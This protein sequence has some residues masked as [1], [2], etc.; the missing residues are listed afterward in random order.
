MNILL[1]TKQGVDHLLRQFF[2]AL[3][4]NIIILGDPQHILS[5]VLEFGHFFPVKR[6]TIRLIGSLLPL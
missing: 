6:Q 3:V 2:F 5:T 4:K 1:C